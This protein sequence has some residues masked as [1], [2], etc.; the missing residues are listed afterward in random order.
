M[1]V[2]STI[3]DIKLGVNLLAQNL[4]DEL[5]L[6]AE[7]KLGSKQMDWITIYIKGQDGFKE[8]VAKRLYHSHIAYMPGYIGS[9]SGVA[10]HD[11]YWIDKN[12]D[13]RAFKQAIGAKTIWKYRIRVYR[14]LEAFVTS[15]NKETTSFT[16]HDLELIEEMRKGQHKIS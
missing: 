14:S 4:K 9:S 3:A 6:G 12:L 10:S 13:D 11:M 8:E 16:D 5:H 15:Q 1:K 2:K 7:E